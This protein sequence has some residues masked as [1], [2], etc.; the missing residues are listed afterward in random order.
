MSIDPK[1]KKCTGTG[2]AIGYGCG[3]PRLERIY[4]LG[5]YCCYPSWLLN[6]EEGKEILAKNNLRNKQNIIKKDAKANRDEKE[7]IKTKANY[8]KELQTVINSIVRLLDFDSHCISC[9]HGKTKQFTR[10]AHASHFWSVG[11]NPQLRF[12][13]HNIHKSCSICNSWKHGNLIQYEKGITER[14][15]NSY[16][17][18]INDLTKNYQSIH[19]DRES[20]KDTIT[21]AKQIK[22]DIERGNDYSRNDI[23]KMLGIYKD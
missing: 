2:K 11:S 1:P 9:D 15:D 22:K 6:S 10:Q 21:V 16:M 8:E 18:L 5:K 20:L 7:S 14:Y 12:N 17:D 3:I 13:L 23:N 19:L 4:G